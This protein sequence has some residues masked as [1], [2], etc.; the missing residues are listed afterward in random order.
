MEK[1]RSCSTAVLCSV[2]KTGL[3]AAHEANSGDF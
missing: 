3:I 2:L 1:F